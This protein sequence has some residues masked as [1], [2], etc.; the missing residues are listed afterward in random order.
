MS[1]HKNII[2]LIADDLGREMMSCYGSKSIKTPHLD[3]LAASGSRF[4][5]AFASTASCSGS[6]TTI[7]TGLH[8]HNNGSYGLN[9]DKN[10]FKT[11]PDIETA[12]HIFNNIGHKTGILSKVHVGPDSQYSWQV[13]YESDSRNVAHI[14]DKAREF[15]SDAIAED[16]PFFLTVGYID[17]HRHVPHRG[18]FGNVEGNYDP[19]LKDRTFSL[20][21]V[22]VPRWLSDLLEV[23]QEFCEYYRSIWRLDQGVGMILQ[24]VKE[25]GLE[26]STMLVFMSDNGPPFINSKTTL[27]DS[28]VHLPF[29]MRVPGR[30]TGIANPNMI[31]WTDVLPTFLDWAGHP[32]RQPGKGFWGPRRGRSFLSIVDHTEVDETWSCVFGSHTFHEVTNY[33]PTRYMRDR[34]YKYHRNVCKPSMIGQ[35]KLNDYIFR[36]PEELY[37]LETDPLE[38]HNLVDDPVH[39]GKLLEMRAALEQ[40]QNDTEDLWLWRDG[41]SVWMY[42]VQGYHREGLRIPDR[43]DFDPTNP[44]NRDLGMPIVELDTS[45]ITK[46]PV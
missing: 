19:R 44:G 10:G 43:F 1:A 9:H 7:Y 27:Y 41:T 33:W 39:R 32:G 14:A 5:L 36:P 13:R 26:D 42:R 28:G 6:K 29:L 20:E 24:Y 3:A 25:L 16:N 12:P 18:G 2:L 17:P 38:V 34:W 30:T 45:K 11:H 46:T 40:W 15:M 23:R 4:D 35:R 31:S 21:D 8:T 37:D 22:V